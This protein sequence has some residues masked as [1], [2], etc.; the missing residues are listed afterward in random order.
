[1]SERHIRTGTE[2]QRRLAAIGVEITSASIS[3]MLAVPPERISVPLLTGL[4]DV[5]DCEPNDLFQMDV[6]GPARDFPV[7]TRSTRALGARPL[8]PRA[9]QAQTKTST[10]QRLRGAPSIPA[11]VEID[12]SVTGPAVVSIT[13]RR[14]MLAKGALASAENLAPTPPD[15]LGPDLSSL[16]YPDRAPKTPAAEGQKRGSRKKPKEPGPD[17]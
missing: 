8:Q 12:P 2:L 14:G 16:A 3:R 13:S 1:M 10:S 11:Q 7:P 6:Y 9:S 15:V 17:A 4:L 5:L